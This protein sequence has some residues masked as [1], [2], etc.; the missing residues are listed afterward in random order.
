M[1][2]AEKSF[3]HRHLCEFTGLDAEMAI[4]AHYSEVM[5]VIDRLFV[6]MFNG[7]ASRCG[8]HIIG[9]SRSTST[10]QRATMHENLK[11]RSVSELNEC[12]LVCSH[13]GQ[14]WPVHATR[15]SL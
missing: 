6:Y 9:L 11:C 10:N 3:T 5:D 14:G 2:R 4:D 12:A 8:A 1:C 7:I 15:R 13:L